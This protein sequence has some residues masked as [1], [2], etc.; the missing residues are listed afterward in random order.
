[1]ARA[2][3]NLRTGEYSFQGKLAAQVSLDVANA[4]AI[5]TITAING[6]RNGSVVGVGVDQGLSN[7]ILHGSLIPFM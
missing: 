4:R 3:F 2:I 6:L 7:F 5:S 1:M